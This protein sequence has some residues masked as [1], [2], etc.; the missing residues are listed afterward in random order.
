MA[1]RNP[2]SNKTELD[3]LVPVT[4]LS[5]DGCYGIEYDI[6]NMN[7]ARCHD[8]LSCGILYRK[9]MQKNSIKS[10]SY[11]DNDLF[12]SLDKNKIR[13]IIKDNNLTVQKSVD[14]VMKLAQ[15]SDR[16]SCEYFI[17]NL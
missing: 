2:K 11:L 14:F 12:N 3:L 4:E 9:Q 7:C 17:K 8:N 13:Q 6:S 15:T 1:K 5:V 16:V 10:G